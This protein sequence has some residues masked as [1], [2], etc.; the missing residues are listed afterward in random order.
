MSTSRQS[1]TRARTDALSLADILPRIVFVR[2][3]RVL[4]SADLADLYSVEVRALVQAVKRNLRRFPSDFAFQLTSDEFARSRSQNVILKLG[5][6]A[7]GKTRRGHNW[8]Y[9][10]WAF[11]EHGVAMLSMVLRSERAVAVSVEIVRTFVRLRSLV[12]QDQ[13]LARRLAAVEAKTD[14]HDEKFQEVFEA[15]EAL[16]L[17]EPPDARTIG[18]DTKESP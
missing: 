17:P 2:G 3:E 5:V 7:P 9:L 14:A 8:K 13:D 11:T 18:F 4:L 10:P 1:P 16:L 12:A 6:A 15:I